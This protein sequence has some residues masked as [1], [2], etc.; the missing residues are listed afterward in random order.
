MDSSLAN[1]ASAAGSSLV[2]P[3][4]PAA[5]LSL[6]RGSIPN[7]KGITSMFSVGGGTPDIICD[8]IYDTKEITASVTNNLTFLNTVSTDLSL[9]N[10]QNANG[11]PSQEA[12]YL[13]GIRWELFNNADAAQDVAQTKEI[14][15]QGYYEF[16]IANKVYNSGYLLWFFNCTS[17]LVVNTRYFTVPNSFKTW[18]LPLPLAIPPLTALNCKVSL[19]A[20]AFTSTDKW[21]LRFVAD[22]FRYRAVQ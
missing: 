1:A 15:R 10:V 16:R 14:F 8:K 7:V 4:D 11:M 19:V 3:S 22:G 12:F 21:Y 18:G 6:N 9:S 2:N 5:M 13:T 17:P 20:P